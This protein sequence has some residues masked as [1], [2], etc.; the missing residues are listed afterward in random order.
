[1][2]CQVVLDI[3]ELQQAILEFAK[4]ENPGVI[5]KHVA[6]KDVEITEEGHGSYE[7]YVTEVTGAMVVWEKK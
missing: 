3:K 2:K 5:P 4:K 6:A 1:M 7:D